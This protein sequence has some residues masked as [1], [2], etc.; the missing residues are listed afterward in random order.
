MLLNNQP[1]FCSQYCHTDCTVTQPK[2][3]PVKVLGPW[4]IMLV[5]A[6]AAALLAPDG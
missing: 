3:E 2:L 4:D 6:M 1:L 5:S